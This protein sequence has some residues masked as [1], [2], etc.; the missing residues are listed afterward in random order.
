MIKFLVLVNKQGKYP[1]LA[2]Q[3][4]LLVQESA[5]DYGKWSAEDWRSRTL[6]FTPEVMAAAGPG[7]T[8]AARTIISGLSSIVSSC[9]RA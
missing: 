6:R 3:A 5:E 9:A 7:G 2:L 1:G 8:A 4:E